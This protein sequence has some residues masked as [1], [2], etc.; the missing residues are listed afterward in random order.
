MGDCI[1]LY[2]IVSLRARAS[3][4]VHKSRRHNNLLPFVSVPGLQT[5]SSTEKQD[6]CMAGIA[7]AIAAPC[8]SRLHGKKHWVCCYWQQRVF[9]S[10][11][12]HHTVIGAF[13]KVVGWLVA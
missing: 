10:S 13:R 6:R 9:T 11:S 3:G 2:S 7:K 4:T 12:E 1:V 5:K 8:K